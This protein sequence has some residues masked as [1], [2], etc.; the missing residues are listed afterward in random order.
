MRPSNGSRTSDSSSQYAK[1]VWWAVV[2][3]IFSAWFM[4]PWKLAST[5]G[6]TGVT[7]FAMLVFA[8]MCNAALYPL[9]KHRRENQP[10]A[11]VRGDSQTTAPKHR[12]WLVALVLALCTLFGNE[13]S[14]RSIAEVTGPVLNV[15]LRTEVVWIALLSALFLRERTNTRFWSGATLA[16]L[17]LFVLHDPLASSAEIGAPGLWLGLLS[18]L[19]FSVM[20]VVTRKYIHEV[21]TV[22][23]NLRRLLISLPL[24]VVGGTSIE[25][26]LGADPQQLVYASL[27]GFCGPVVSRLCL[28]QSARYVEARI[29]AVTVQL[30]PPFTVALSFLFFGELPQARE[31]LGGAL[32]LLGVVLTIAPVRSSLRAS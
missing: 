29:T 11:A 20:A 22:R 31:W 6:P 4:I 2:S 26:L 27:A 21:D 30:A 14:A 17:G 25:T 7:V 12:E 5:R 9:L 23:L 28:M 15:L 3:A 18:A 13:L 19:V 10:S 1:G 16:G 24:C 32:M 8:A